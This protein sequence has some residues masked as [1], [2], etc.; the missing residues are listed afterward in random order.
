M[1]G[2][3]TVSRARGFGVVDTG[4]SGKDL[5]RWWHLGRGWSRALRYL[6]SVAVKAQQMQR[7]W[8]RTRSGHPKHDNEARGAGAQR[9]DE[10]VLA[11]GQRE[12]WGLGLC[13]LSKSAEAFDFIE[14]AGKQ[15]G[16]GGKEWQVQTDL[17]Q[18]HLAEAQRA[19]G[20]LGIRTAALLR[21]GCGRC[22][23][24]VL[25]H[26]RALVGRTGR[27]CWRTSRFTWGLKEIDVNDEL[28]IFGSSNCKNGVTGTRLGEVA[29]MQVG[30]W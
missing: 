28:H 5:L 17:Y 22:H 12:C 13:Q 18:T 8:A 23:W 24:E 11:G 10:R 15:W 29:E 21:P 1:P 14:W 20:R 25:P 27:I 30:V 3:S 7:P 16:V 4:K 26:C 9:V 6:K 19:R 2:C